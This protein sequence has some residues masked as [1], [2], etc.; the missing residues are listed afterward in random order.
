MNYPPVDGADSG[1][2][3]RD[4]SQAE[5][6]PAG[7]GGAAAEAAET[8][9]RGL[10]S[11]VLGE[12]RFGLWVDQALEIVPTPPISRLPL[13]RREVAGVTSVRGDVVPVLD[14]GL[15]LLDAPAVRPGRLVLVRDE[16]SGTMVGLLVDGVETLVEVREGEI[17]DP[18]PPA[19]ARL[20]PELV[21]GVVARDEG[22]VTILNLGRA[23]APPEDEPRES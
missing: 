14:L 20:A 12:S 9:G 11:L 23:A 17:L 7:R 15:R 21:E 2:G 10:L 18:P 1:A 22:V 16:E 13:P 19:E 3:P 8:P 6:V 4:P 5:P